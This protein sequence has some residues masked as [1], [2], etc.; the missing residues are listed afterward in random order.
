MD[1]REGIKMRC[2]HGTGI[3]SS[4]MGKHLELVPN[5]GPVHSGT[6]STKSFLYIR[7]WKHKYTVD[8]VAWVDDCNEI[9][10]HNGS[11]VV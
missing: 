6:P 3:R 8:D 5:K 11:R 7:G 10:T 1:R 2:I 9:H 4:C